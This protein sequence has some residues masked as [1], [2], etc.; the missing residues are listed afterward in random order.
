MSAG[1]FM[2][3]IFFLLKSSR[4]GVDNSILEVTIPFVSLLLAIAGSYKIKLEVAG[5][6]KKNTS[7]EKVR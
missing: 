4:I 3:I 5:L 2:L 1:A 7:Q 6:D